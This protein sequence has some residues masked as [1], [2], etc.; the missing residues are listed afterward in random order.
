MGLS[1]AAHDKPDTQHWLQAASALVQTFS[2]C[3]TSQSKHSI[4]CELLMHTRTHWTDRTAQRSTLFVLL[5]LCD[6]CSFDDMRC[7]YREPKM[8]PPKSCVRQAYSLSRTFSRIW[9]S[10]HTFVFYTDKIN[11]LHVLIFQMKDSGCVYNSTIVLNSRMLCIKFSGVVLNIYMK[12]WPT[13][14]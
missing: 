5:S 11:T 6:C 9:N 10:F 2:C 1:V 8:Q 7:L 3:Q 4:I 12:I 14:I 13:T